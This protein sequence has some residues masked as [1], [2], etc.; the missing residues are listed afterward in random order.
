M[1]R[2]ILHCD[3][4][5]FYAS[6]E[7]LYRPDLKG[8]PVAV[9]GSQDSRR[10]VVLAK[11]MYAK[12]KG[13]KTG[14]A[15]WEARLKCP[16][17]R[18]VFPDYKKYFRFSKEVRNI[19]ARYTT[20]IESFGIDECWLDI[21]DSIRLFGS[22]EKIAE[23]IRKETEFELGITVS[24]G[25]SFNKIFAKLAS[26]KAE[27]NS[28]SIISR[29]NYKNKVWSLP[30]EELLFVGRA[31]RRKFRNIGIA[32]IGDLANTSLPFLKGMLGKWGGNPV[33]FCKWL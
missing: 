24:V 22:G 8:L 32:T 12:E 20:M 2:V 30:V 10:G 4:N 7:C 13:V 31:T 28:I 5:C 19:Y 33:V 15:I 14:E 17:L 3:L 23:L 6:V 27:P 25:L 9:C 16:G 1:D 26:D 29:E 11:N 21:T 18:T